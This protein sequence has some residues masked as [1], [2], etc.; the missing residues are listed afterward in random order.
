MHTSAS[1]M[2]GRR[3]E[4]SGHFDKI[5][6]PV[7]KA[8]LLRLARGNGVDPRRVSL[9]PDRLYREPGEADRAYEAVAAADLEA[10][11]A[12]LGPWFHNI[13]LPDGTQTAPDHFLGDF[14]TFKWQQL[15]GVLPA[16]LEGWTVL[17][18]GCNAG[19]YSLELAK[20]GATV[21]GTDLNPHYLRQ[22]AWAAGVHGLSDRVRYRRMQVYDLA[23]EEATYDLV[24]FMGVFYHLRYPLLG[25]DIVARTVGRLAVFQT[26]TLP[27]EEVV[28]DTWD[29]SLHDRDDLLLPGWPRMAFVEHRFNGDPTNWW[30]VN[31]AGAEAML[32]SSGLRVIG[33]PGHEFYL[34]EP[35]PE[36]PSCV[37]GWNREEYLAATGYG[38]RDDP[39]QDA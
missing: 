8:D 21:T 33:R 1:N 3:T 37:A 38:G 18:V 35:D 22:A 12:A 34:C 17:D 5:V 24:L 20:R 4:P 26:L 23:R 39:G 28:A 2:P 15:A 6:F 36:H 31:H 16:S 7:A 9:M 32:R 13:H 27:G 10:A 30:I 19:F 29:R 25:L 14:P 11:I